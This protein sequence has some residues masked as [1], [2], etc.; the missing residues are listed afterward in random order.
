MTKGNSLRTLSNLL[1]NTAKWFPD[2]TAF[3]DIDEN[4]T[5]RIISY[6]NFVELVK[7]L[8]FFLKEV[9]VKKNDKIILKSENSI[10][11]AIYFF[12]INYLGAVCVPLDPKLSLEELK[13]VSF[14]SESKLC[15][16][17]ENQIN[18]LKV[19]ENEFFKRLLTIDEIESY[20]IIENQPEYNEVACLIYTSGTTGNPKAVMLSNEN[21]LANL[22]S[23]SLLNLAKNTDIFLCL[24]PF[25]HSFPLMVNLLLPVYY[26]ASSIILKSLKSNII[27]DVMKAKK[28]TI[29]PAVPLFYKNLM[30]GILRKAR[31]N[32]FNLLYLNLYKFC[33]YIRKILKFNLGKLLFFPIQKKF[34]GNLRFLISGGARLETEVFK[35]FYGIGFNILEGYGL[36]E[37]SP[38]VSFNPLSK[39]KEGS[40]G[41]PI[42]NVQV[43][44]DKKD[45]SFDG[46]ILVKGNNVMIGYWKNEVLTKEVIT[47]GWLRTGD[48]GYLDKDGYLFITGRKKEIIVLSN[49]KN[50]YP[51]EIEDFFYKNVRGIEECVAIPVFE[52]NETNLGI[53]IKPSKLS[54]E[55]IRKNILEVMKTMPDYK[56][57]KKIFFTDEEIPKTNLGKYK[58]TLVANLFSEKIE[59]KDMTEAFFVKDEFVREVIN[60]I[61]N[62]LD[63]KKIVTYDSSFEIDL[64]L[65]SLK[66]VELSLELEEK[67]GIKLPEGFMSDIFFVKDLIERLRK[68]EIKDL[69]GKEEKRTFEE[70]ILKELD[71]KEITVIEKRDVIYK[72]LFEFIIFVFVKLT[73]KIF[74]KLKVFGFEHLEKTAE[75]FIIAPNHL[76]YLDGYVITAILPFKLKR[77]LFFIGLADFFDKTFL[78]IFKEPAGVL[79]FDETLEPIKAIR[80]SIFVIKKGYNLCIF[81]EGAR[82]YDGN[83]MEL[84]KGIA[85]IVK[86]TN[87]PVLP[88]FING[89]FEAWPRFRKL[90]RF[91]KNIEIRIGEPIYYTKEEDENKFLEKL[92][93]NLIRLSKRVEKN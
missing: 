70:L 25:Y 84:R 83:L 27:L 66:K 31:D 20:E 23:I 49:G 42:P 82:S 80:A 26:G 68:I 46:E 45:D 61:S 50:I 71:G 11:W 43:Q 18:V 8:S 38:V 47:E 65:D 90:P 19:S 75:P 57:P 79:S 32:K 74:Y 13:I 15:I 60:I 81:P 39:I 16:L 41:I 69:Y 63:G 36:T 73:S 78:K 28:I 85:Y 67:L 35:F 55:E 21:Y 7:K 92:K 17:S 30:D 14:D 51:E 87:A 5:E 56:R 52:K 77:K 40:V 48:V 33:Y 37:A 62:F 59:K 53:V 6:K 93:K 29:L 24:L 86:N 10:E 2:K 44:I 91:F 4:G 34:G 3:I 58:R 89:T 88:V 72:R 22:E 12:S 54:E 9:G 76:S 1:I 64:G